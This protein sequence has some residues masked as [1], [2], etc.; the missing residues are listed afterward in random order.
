M[1]SRVLRFRHPAV[2]WLGLVASLACIPCW[3][4]IAPANSPDLHTFTPA[5]GKTITAQ[6]ASV[7]DSTVALKGLDGIIHRIAIADLNKEDQAYLVRWQIR[8]ALKNGS[9]IFHF[10]LSSATLEPA[11]HQAGAAGAPDLASYQVTLTNS[12]SFPVVQPTIQY[13][14]LAFPSAAGTLPGTVPDRYSGTVPTD[15]LAPKA[16]LRFDTVKAQLVHHFGRLLGVWVRVYDAD[17]VLLQDWCSNPEVQKTQPWVFETSTAGS[18]TATPPT[19]QIPL[20]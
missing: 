18:R 7:T 13:L 11:S 8:N 4:A 10:N 17:H 14:L 15:T 20:L 9:K 12:S 2:Y 19:I 1:T 5:D 6:P 16:E 3:A